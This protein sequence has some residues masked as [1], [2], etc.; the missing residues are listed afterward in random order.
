MY[1]KERDKSV[2]T[3]TALKYIHGRGL[4]QFLEIITFINEER[5]C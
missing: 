3:F 4:Q 5:L 1:E 2:Q